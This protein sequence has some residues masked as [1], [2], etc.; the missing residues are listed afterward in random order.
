VG[1]AERQHMNS[2]GVRASVSDC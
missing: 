1:G 2:F